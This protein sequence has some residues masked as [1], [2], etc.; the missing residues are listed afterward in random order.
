[1]PPDVMG[2][3]AERFREQQQQHG[4]HDSL[5]RRPRGHAR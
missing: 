1:M 5:P 2:R 4:V 3:D